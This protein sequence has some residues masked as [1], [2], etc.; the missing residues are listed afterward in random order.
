[1]KIKIIWNKIVQELNKHDAFIL[2]NIILVM[3]FVFGVLA[4]YLYTAFIISP[5]LGILILI[6]GFGILAWFAD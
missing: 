6:I 1:M 3:L 5:Y 4:Y 2:Y